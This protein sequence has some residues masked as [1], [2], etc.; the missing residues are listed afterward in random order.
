MNAWLELITDLISTVTIH[1]WWIGGTYEEKDI[2]GS[3][4]F[5]QAILAAEMHGQILLDNHTLTA[6]T[7]G[8]KRNSSNLVQPLSN[9]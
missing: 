5:I 4:T 7:L 2:R 3:K 8:S 9:L 1:S 6:C